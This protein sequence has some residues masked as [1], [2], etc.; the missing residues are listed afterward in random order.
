MLQQQREQPS[1]ESTLVVMKG[2][3]IATNGGVKKIRDNQ[4]VKPVS[5]HHVLYRR[6]DGSPAREL[7]KVIRR[8]SMGFYAS[9]SVRT[10]SSKSEISYLSSDN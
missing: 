8:E 2:N 6:A 4:L 3:L 10:S 1:I 5:S 9:A 7:G